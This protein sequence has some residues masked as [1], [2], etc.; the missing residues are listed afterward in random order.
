M[1]IARKIVKKRGALWLMSTL[2][3]HRGEIYTKKQCE[4]FLGR[5]L[6]QDEI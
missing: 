2:P 4:E 3:N 6:A 5:P 1:R